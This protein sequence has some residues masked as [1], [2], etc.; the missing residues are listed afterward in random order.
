M[1]AYAADFDD[2]RVMAATH[3][4]REKGPVGPTI[5]HDDTIYWS[6]S[7]HKVRGRIFLWQDT[8]WDLTERGE[9]HS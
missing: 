2:A 3:F 4:T 7:R 5:D 1:I 6:C 8:V 9:L